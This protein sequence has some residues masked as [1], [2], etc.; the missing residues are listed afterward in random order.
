MLNKIP[1]VTVFFWMIKIMA[2][3]VGE[4]GADFLIF[5]LHLGI[6]VT[7]L[8]AG[9]MLV[10]FLLIQLRSRNYVPWMY[11][12]TVVLVSI[13]GTLVT[14]NLVDNFGVPLEVTTAIFLV[15]LMVTFAIWYACEK[16]LSI[17]TVNTRRREL[18]Y[19]TAILFTFALGTAAGDLVAEGLNLGYALSALCFG[20]LIALV[21]VIYAVLQSGATAWFWLAYILTRP[22]G[23]SFGDLLSQDPAK[24]GLGLGTIATSGIFLVA[25]VVLVTYLTVSG[26]DAINEAN[27]AQVH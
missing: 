6:S 12:I 18:F 21:G 13:F 11:W 23:A 15:A 9:S 7:S 16:S 19:W 14:D 20:A 22:F 25:I 26:R 24:G 2:T 4:T 8:I 10:I 1:A 5:N 17:R 27:A 3:T